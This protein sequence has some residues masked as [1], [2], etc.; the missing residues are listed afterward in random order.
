MSFRVDAKGL[1]THWYNII[2]DLP[3]ELPPDI[4]PPR[5]EEATQSGMKM[6]IPLSLVRQNTTRQRDIPIPD[7]VLDHYRAWRT[8]PLKRALHL[9]AHLGTTARIYFKYEGGNASGSHKLS[10]AIAQAHYYKAA[11]ATRLTTGTGAGQWGT[12]LAIGC[13]AFGM[14]CRVYMVGSSYRA[15]PYRRTIMQLYGANVLSSPSTQTHFGSRLAASGMDSGNIAF[16]VTEAL[17]DAHANEGSQLSVGSGENY[18]ILHSTVIGIEARQQLLE[19]GHPPDIVV[20]SLGAGSNFGGIAFP[21]LGERLRGE[22]NVRCVSVEPQACPKLTRGVYRYD[23]TDGSG[24]TPL[25]KMYTLGHQFK[26]AGMHA[27]GLRYHAC[28][29]LISALYH[30]KQIDAVAYAQR[31]VFE[32]AV[33]F[34]QLEGILPAPE[35]AHAVHG[36]IQE[37][38]RA[39]EEGRSPTILFCLSGHGMF[40]LAAYAE[41]LDGSMENVEVSEEEIQRSR[42][43]L[44]DIDES[45]AV[46]QELS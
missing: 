20:A 44:P 19:L 9:E 41:Y 1:P 42:S 43:L 15:K 5:S 39:R 7:E 10:T 4:Q 8:T 22:R 24:V 26:P 38:I 34:S 12:A 11:G 23:Y 36:A 33:L 28:S 14:D 18:S 16:A 2:G 37:A 32:S 25:Q 27:G 46:A 35:S 3:F 17:E 6:Q 40:D 30:H 31:D 13:R 29:K 45:Q 21:F